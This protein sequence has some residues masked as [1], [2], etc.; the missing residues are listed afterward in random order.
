MIRTLE[1]VNFRRHE[2]SRMDFSADAQ[3]VAISGP[4]GSGKSTI[5]EALLFAL[6]GQ[7]RHGRNGMAGL[8]RRGAEHEGMSV[9]LEF[10]LA[11][12][13]C[14]I[15]RRYEKGKHSAA[16][17]VND[18]LT[19]QTADAV[20]V[21]V[22]EMLGMD[23]VGFRLATIAKQKELD[24]LA[25]MLPSARRKT[26][27]RL[28]RLDAV[29]AAVLAARDTHR[30]AKAGS[31][32][33]SGIASVAQRTAELTDAQGAAE[34]AA[35][36]TD[37]AR[38]GLHG[39]EA[40]LGSLSGSEDEYRT[41][42]THLARAT[43]IADAAR[44]ELGRLTNEQS[45]S[46]PPTKPAYDG[47]TLAQVNVELEQLAETIA[48]CRAAEQA[49]HNLTQAQRRLAAAKSRL[50]QAEA[51]AAE[52]DDVTQVTVTAA[53]TALAAAVTEADQAS[54]HA[55]QTQ[56]SAAAA[57]ARRDDTAAR[58]TRSEDLGDICDACGQDVPDSH[59][60]QL[61]TDLDAAA[62]SAETEAALTATA[63]TS[64]AAAAIAASRRV[65][66]ARNTL[67]EARVALARRGATDNAVTEA[68]RAV[69]VYTEDVERMQ[70]PE[71]KV[72]IDD[73]YRRR[74][75]L[76]TLRA[77]ADSHAQALAAHAG[78]V[79]R[80]EQLTIAVAEATGRLDEAEKAV[81]E[82]QPGEALVAAW[83]R[84]NELARVVA[85]ERDFVAACTAAQA[86][87]DAEVGTAAKLLAEAEKSAAKVDQ[88]RT[89]AEVAGKTA[90]LLDAL[91]RRM[92][93][94]IRPQLEGQ[95]SALL[96]LMSEGR[97]TAVK[98]SDDYDIEVAD[99][100]AKFYPVSEFSGGEADLI[101]LALRLA[102]AQVVSA[103]HGAGGAGFLVLDEIFGSLDAGR[104][105][106]V[107]DALRRLRAQYGQIL[108]ISHV[109][110][111]E[112]AADMIVEV[113]RDEEEDATA[114]VHL[115]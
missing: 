10:D 56:A 51:D 80:H 106:A 54:A 73:A 64:A 25:Q 16:L 53:E 4:N 45:R 94:Q 22:G 95:V 46:A 49:Q 14:K 61:R 11:G 52:E 47:P 40:E 97:F 100:D 66:A 105:T 37:E 32:A 72:S 27:S 74:T 83:E 1:L 113:D 111:L 2:R 30:S 82:A 50:D 13:M 36:A 34:E 108:L 21:R 60:H 57:A 26:I 89:Q 92:A 81:V 93:T 23:A 101:A 114:R 17:Y 78:A 48:T 77:E 35:A 98:I 15:E 91:S 99:R 87:A 96:Q 90:T 109:G 59:K 79:V 84:R 62:E 103:R 65:D 44:G 86:T 20:S 76:E 8:V 107:L 28:L 69:A 68:R 24:G 115:I 43:A 42:A 67:D 102:L 7:T 6:Y 33:L 12:A 104:R 9:L 85:A 29:N 70:V 39:V 18:T 75:E 63:A 110:G 88:Y 38:A 112:D 5:L 3:I 58:A 71:V 41:A 19:T 55:R 31:D